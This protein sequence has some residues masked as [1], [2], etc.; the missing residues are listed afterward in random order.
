MV[1]VFIVLFIFFVLVA[2]LARVLRFLIVLE[3]MRRKK[4]TN[5]FYCPYHLSRSDCRCCEDIVSDRC[6]FGETPE[7]F[8]RIVIANMKRVREANGNRA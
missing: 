2:V 6:R 5:D 3:R 8:A 4:M 1:R 7:G